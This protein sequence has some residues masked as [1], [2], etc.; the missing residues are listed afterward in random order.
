MRVGDPP[1]S[2][3]EIIEQTDDPAIR[4][5][6]R[7]AWQEGFANG[8]GHAAQMDAIAAEP[9]MPI[10]DPLP[11]SLETVTYNDDHEPVFGLLLGVQ[12]YRALVANDRGG[13]HWVDLKEVRVHYSPSRPERLKM[14]W[15]RKSPPGWPARLNGDE[16]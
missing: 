4:S 3:G 10:A 12:G 11:C 5:A 16:P 8:V 7:D 13:V 15:A 1:K 14:G 9:A 2:L 6:V